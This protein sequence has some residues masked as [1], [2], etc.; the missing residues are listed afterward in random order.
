MND[1]FAHEIAKEVR[2]NHHKILSD[3]CKAYLAQHYKEGHEINP[4]ML[5]LNEQQNFDLSNGKVGNRYWFELGVPYYKPEEYG[6]SRWTC[7]RQSSPSKEYPIIVI[8]E[9]DEFPKIVKFIED[10]IYGEP[11]FFE[12]NGEYECTEENIFYWMPAPIPPIKK[13]N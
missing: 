9:F 2:E 4:K 3:W 5:T 7:A 12:S 8:T 13:E 6:W 10:G 1:N 11:S